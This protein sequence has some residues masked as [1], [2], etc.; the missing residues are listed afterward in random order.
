[1]LKMLIDCALS[2]TGVG[3]SAK[4]ELLHE[5]ESIDFEQGR[6]TFTNGTSITADL[7]I[8]ADGVVASRSLSRPFIPSH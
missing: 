5:A 6:V 7:I 2:S 4:L 1:M 3:P 8:G